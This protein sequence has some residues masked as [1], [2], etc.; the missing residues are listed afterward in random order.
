VSL[1]AAAGETKPGFKDGMTEQQA[2]G[3]KAGLAG[4]RIAILAGVLA[5]AG[6]ATLY[7]IMGGV[8]KEADAACAPAQALA[9][10]LAPLAHGEIAA[11]SIDK[12]PRRAVKVSFDGPDGAKRSLADFHGK[13]VL[14]NLWATWCVPCR[15]EMPSLDRLQAKLGGP[16]FEVVAVN[17]DT[18]RLERRQAFLKSAGVE[19]LDFYSD[20]S[21]DIF[22]Q[23]RKA[24]KALGLPTSLIVDRNGCEIGVM[25]GPANWASDDAAKF[26]AELK[27]EKTS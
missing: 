13:T 7:G 19:A 21:A 1:G 4:R 23:L 17:I 3:R 14:L 26:I 8:R 9:A 10:R 2:S 16:D 12:Q 20:S 6:A 25:A 11:L 5:L 24:G 18:A 15:E 27:S 22:Q